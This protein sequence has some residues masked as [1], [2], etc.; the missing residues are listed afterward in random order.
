MEGLSFTVRG[1]PLKFDNGWFRGFEKTPA[2]VDQDFLIIDTTEAWVFL[3]K[4]TPA[5]YVVREP[6]TPMRPA[7]PN[8]FVAEETWPLYN[9]KPSDPWRYNAIIHLLATANGETFHFASPTA[10]MWIC[11]DELLEQ[12]RS[13]RQLQPGSLPI[14]RLASTSWK[15]NFGTR[16]RPMLRI[17]GWQRPKT[18]H[19]HAREETQLISNENYAGSGPKTIETQKPETAKA[20]PVKS[21]LV[22]PNPAKVEP[23][24]CRAG[25]SRAEA[26]RET[27]DEGQNPRRGNG[28]RQPVRRQRPILRSTTMTELKVVTENEGAGPNPFDIRKLRV[29][30][31][32]EQDA[33]QRLQLINDGPGAQAEKKQ[34][35]ISRPRRSG[36]PRRPALPSCGRKG[37]NITSSARIWLA[38]C[39]TT[40]WS[41]PCTP[42]STSPAL[43]SCGR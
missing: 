40:Q 31:T 1:V 25:G 36:I 21:D 2:P 39:K 29:P 28:H 23:V 14:V 35:W 43:C 26:D 8:T 15:T 38:S 16:Q 18:E 17:V 12:I 27:H 13:M 33:G 42:R 32:Y 5:E 9:D 4:G 19:L 24:K 7:R 34:E 6:G 10:G 11:R 3:K 37:A 41:A 30:P 22:K 20:E